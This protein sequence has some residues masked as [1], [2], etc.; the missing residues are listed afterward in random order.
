[1]N[2]WQ[3]LK[4]NTP[5]LVF[6]Y[7]LNV[8]SSF[9]QTYVH[10]QFVPEIIA[11]FGFTN[12]SFGSIYAAATLGGGLSLIYFGK[13]IDEYP[14]RTYTL[15]AV[16]VLGLACLMIGL[17]ENSWV[18]LLALFLNRLS[19][20]GLLT[21]ISLTTIA[22]NFSKLRGKALSIAVLGHSTG[23]AIFP[24]TLAV[25]IGAAGWRT[26]SVLDA[27]FILLVLLPVV[28]WLTRKPFVVNEQADGEP[29]AGPAVNTQRQWT[30]RQVLGD[31]RLYLL[32]PAIFTTHFLVTGYH[33]YQAEIAGFKDWSV[34]W[35]AACFVVYAISRASASI[36]AG[37]LI[38]RLGAVNL[39]PFFLL[40][41]VA[42]LL[43]LQFFDS[44]L[45]AIPYY[46]GMAASTGMLASLNSAV[47][48]E[49]YG[50]QSL[51]AIRSMYGTLVVASTSASPLVIGLMLD[52]G[53]GFPV[54]IASSV[55]LMLLAAFAALPVMI[56][57]RRQ[58]VAGVR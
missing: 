43:C 7:L 58:Q 3:L 52:N 35:L 17:A 50:V 56:T 12:T 13:L 11:S 20:Q 25:L 47:L 41:F 24:V 21:H 44:R 4:K 10:A 55:G 39:M 40:P 5:V 54:V 42:S 2:Y 26:A 30:R 49:L 16:S 19:G 53:L 46:M 34:S 18:L 8:F 28:W 14:L 1:M 37:I 51:G 9:G 31:Y 57:Y 45:A 29:A 22:R 32:V 6:G 23:Q 33:F 48:A 38:D 15:A 27:A 36:F